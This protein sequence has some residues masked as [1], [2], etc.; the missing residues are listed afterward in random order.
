MFPNINVLHGSINQ[1]F[2]QLLFCELQYRNKLFCEQLM[3]LE[4]PIFEVIHFEMVSYN[5][6]IHMDQGNHTT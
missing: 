2:G 5:R 1:T 3:V 4:T 6:K